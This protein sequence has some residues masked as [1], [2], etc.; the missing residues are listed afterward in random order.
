MEKVWD[1]HLLLDGYLTALVSLSVF[2]RDYYQYKLEACVGGTSGDLEW[3]ELS[4]P[5]CSVLCPSC[6][7]EGF[8]DLDAW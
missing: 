7:T 4:T 5:A 8:A 1:S 3:P 2:F 6:C